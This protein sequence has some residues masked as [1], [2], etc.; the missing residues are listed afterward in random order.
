[1]EEM[2]SLFDYLGYAAGHE[3]GQNVAEYA[4]IRKVIGGMRSVSNP[5]YKGP[6]MLY[7]KEFI[8]EYFAVE[9]LFNGKDYTEI[10]TELTED[11]FKVAAVEAVY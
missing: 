7:T 1:M 10:N 9:K 2:L 11:S 3:L 4:K 8:D 6:V 5:K